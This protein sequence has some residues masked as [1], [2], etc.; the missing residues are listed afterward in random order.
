MDALRTAIEVLFLD[1]DFDK[2]VGSI[3]EAVPQ[4][5]S[6]GM[7]KE[8]NERFTFFFSRRN[9]MFGTNVISLIPHYLES[10]AEGGFAS[11]SPFNLIGYASDK[12]L[13]LVD[14]E[15]VCRYDSYLRWNEITAS[16]GEDILT[17][18][19]LFERD[20]IT[21]SYR[22][23]FAWKPILAAESN[24]VNNVIENGLSELHFHLKGSSSVFDLNWLVLMNIPVRK[25]SEVLLNKMSQEEPLYPMLVK[26][27]LIRWTLFSIVNGLSVSHKEN[28]L[29]LH[30]LLEKGE[31]IDLWSSNVQKLVS[32]TRLSYGYRDEKGFVVDYA[33]P[34]SISGSDCN[35][36]QNIIF[37][38][39]RKLLYDCFWYIKERKTEYEKLSKLLYAY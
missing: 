23:S 1:W 17:T 5:E 33:I 38:G 4:S 8:E 6:I 10:S 22:K 9:G 39:E 31:N 30:V 20:F 34:S 16:I 24:G 15:P 11:I 19:F 25:G 13:T 37:I 28:A 36:M 7:S 14:D 3:L 18:I 2:A 27:A 32:L 21:H 26:A 12:M 35:R 29:L